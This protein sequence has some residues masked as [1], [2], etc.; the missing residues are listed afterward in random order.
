MSKQRLARAL[1]S[2]AVI[3]TT[4][5]AMAQQPSSDQTQGRF[6]GTRGRLSS[7]S[8][9]AG[10]AARDSRTGATGEH[11]ASG[12]DRH[13]VHCLTMGNQEEI[14]LSQLAQQRSTNEDVKQFA[15]QMVQDHTKF[16]NRLQGQSGAG[17]QDSSGANAGESQRGNRLQHDAN[18]QTGS[19]RGESSGATAGASQQDNRQNDA[20]RQSGAGRGETSGTTTGAS[21]GENRL[22]NDA[23]GQSGAGRSSNLADQSSRRRGNF[24]ARGGAAQFL[25]VLDEVGR[26]CQQTKIQ[27]LSQKSGHQFDMAYMGMQAGAHLKMAD[28]LT[29]FSKHA[30]ESLRPILEEGLQTTKQHLARAKEIKQR[31][32]QE[33]NKSTA[34]R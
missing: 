12:V 3:G 14:A 22:Q 21:Q 23:N 28:E 24:G 29:V 18:T 34:S 32:E 6:S 20:N 2:A 11:Q 25:Q 31:L 8:Q 30:S 19:A 9:T 13:M 33:P 26:Q 17:Q 1:W 15:A 16:L 27:E 5:L 4:G 7:E 10:D